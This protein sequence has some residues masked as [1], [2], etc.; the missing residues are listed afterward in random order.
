MTAP[1]S[2]PARADGRKAR[3]RQRIAS[4]QPKQMVGGSP[5]PAPYR[6]LGD[7]DVTRIH[8]AALEL[9]ERVGIASPAPF[10]HTGGR[11]RS[12]RLQG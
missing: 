5:L 10:G 1:S 2:P 3:R 7:G 11:T 6:P 8:R 9:L 12:R 4:A